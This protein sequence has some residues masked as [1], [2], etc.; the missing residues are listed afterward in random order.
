MLNTLIPF[1]VLILVVVFDPLAVT[2]VIAYNASLLR[3]KN[4]L[5]VEAEKQG[6][7]NT[8]TTTHHVKL[9]CSAQNSAQT[10]IAEEM[11]TSPS[12]MLSKRRFILAETAALSISQ[13]ISQALAP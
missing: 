2:L 10:R 13:S 6:E 3:G 7:N 11:A 4:P 8:D 5:P 9:T 12:H 1:L